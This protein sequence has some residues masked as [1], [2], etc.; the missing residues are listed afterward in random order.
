MLPSKRCWRGS[1]PAPLLHKRNNPMKNAAISFADGG[2]LSFVLEFMPAV[3][4]RIWEDSHPPVSSR[5][6]DRLRR[7]PVFLVPQLEQKF[8]LVSSPA[9]RAGPAV[10]FRSL[11]PTV[12]AELPLVFL[13]AAG[14]GPTSL[15]RPFAGH[16][17]PG[18]GGSRLG[19][20]NGALL[21]GHLIHLTGIGS[22]GLLGKAHAQKP[23]HGPGR[24]AGGGF[25][26]RWPELRP[27]VRP[28]CR[29]WCRPRDSWN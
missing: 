21:L 10:G 2:V 23:S 12:G 1:V 6:R 28:S 11:F 8:A 24:I 16:R 19:R 17:R 13:A 9:F 5:S 14:A 25:H 27:A 20:R 7:E 18:G 29:D 22:P 3:W 15:R 26:G 4:G